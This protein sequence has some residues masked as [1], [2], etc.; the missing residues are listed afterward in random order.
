MY[1]HAAVPFAA[2]YVALSPDGWVLA[3]VAKF[4]ADQQ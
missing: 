2:N 4:R 1:F 3:I